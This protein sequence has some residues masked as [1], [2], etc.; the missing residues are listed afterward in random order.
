VSSKTVKPIKPV[1]PFKPINP[2]PM[3][4]AVPPVKLKKTAAY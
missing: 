3:P 2:K 4:E 1:K